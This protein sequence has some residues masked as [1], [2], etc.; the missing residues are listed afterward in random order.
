MEPQSGSIGRA[1]NACWGPASSA[2]SVSGCSV[3]LSGDGKGIP[4]MNQDATDA[5]IVDNYRL[6]HL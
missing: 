4:G 5:E 1:I 2:Q 3:H 6:D